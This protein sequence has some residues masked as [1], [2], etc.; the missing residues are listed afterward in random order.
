MELTLPYNWVPRD[1]QMPAWLALEEGIQKSIRGELGVNRALMFWHRRAGKDLFCVNLCATQAMQRILPRQV[2][3]S[4]GGGD[5]VPSRCSRSRL[6]VPERPNGM[7]A[8]ITSTSEGVKPRRPM[9]PSKA[10]VPR[11][12]RDRFRRS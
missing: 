5:A 10:V 1:Y 11:L 8:M 4:G 9:C 3:S 2:G 12:A 7:P 6:V